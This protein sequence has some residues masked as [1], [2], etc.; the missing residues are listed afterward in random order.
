MALLLKLNQSGKIVDVE[1]YVSHGL[2]S[3]AAMRYTAIG[4][5]C[6]IAPD[7]LREAAELFARKL[8]GKMTEATTSTGQ[9]HSPLT[10]SSKS[11]K[12][13]PKKLVE[14]DLIVRRH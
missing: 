11:S 12:P 1:H 8:E 10:F 3:Q 7:E 14:D 9:G 5:I 4:V 13:Q 2:A 6:R